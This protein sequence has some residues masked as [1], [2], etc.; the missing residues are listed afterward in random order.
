MENI[1]EKNIKF[2][3]RLPWIF[4]ILPIL[5]IMAGFFGIIAFSLANGII[6]FFG[7]CLILLMIRGIFKSLHNL[8]TKVYLTENKITIKT[9]VISDNVVDIA[10]DKSE[11]VWVS[12]GIF[13]KI[14]NYGQVSI[15][16]AG[17]N[18]SQFINNP[19]EFRNLIN[20][21]TI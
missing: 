2:Q 5:S 13:G 9:G 10:L 15:T 11:G 6:K 12:Q 20:N 17:M 1:A 8:T 4:N 19:M 3:T 7:L 16:T 14:F 21:H 18:I